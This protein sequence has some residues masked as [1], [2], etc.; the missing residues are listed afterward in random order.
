MPT[1]RTLR[2]FARLLETMATLRSPG[3]CPWDA[4]QTPETLKPYLLEEAYEVLE[5]ID[6]N[7]PD[8]ICDELGDLLLQIVFHARIYEERRLFD[9]GDVATAITDKLIRRHPHVF[10]ADNQQPAPS[11]DAQWERIKAE[12]RRRRG[13]T[14]TAL[15]GVPR[16][17]PA[18]LRARKLTEKASRVGFDWPDV[19]GVF[20]KVQEEFKEFEEAFRSNDQQAMVDELGDILFAIVNLGRFLNIDAEEALRGTINRFMKRFAHI[21]GSLAGRGKSFS[22]S[23]LEELEALWREAKRLE[24]G[25]PGGASKT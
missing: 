23:T 6:R 21:E 17:L 10:S 8:L 19:D 5:A 4:D 14:L 16:H 7:E 22:Q 18:L 11:L 12:E 15:G 2:A 1:D 9:I 20:A 13:E 25:T 3:G 24:G